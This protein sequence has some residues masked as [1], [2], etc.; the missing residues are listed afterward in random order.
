MELFSRKRSKSSEG[1][2]PDHRVVR[3]LRL[4]GVPGPSGLLGLSFLVSFLLRA[5]HYEHTLTFVDE[6]FF[7]SVAA[8]LMHGSVLYRDV[9]CNNQPLVIY[10]CNSLFQILGAHAIALHLGSLLL[11][12]LESWLLYQVGSHFFTARA[13]G[14]AALAYAVISTNFYTP[15]IIGF[16]SE[17]L[18]VVFTT[19]AVYLLLHALAGDRL[20]LLFWTGAFSFA[21]AASKPA[22][23]PEFLALAS[24]LACLAGLSWKRKMRALA[25]MGFGCAAGITVMIAALA[26]AATLHSWWNQS[27]VSRVHYVNQIGGATFLIHFARQPLIFGF[28]Y[29]W[30]WILIWGGRRSADINP[31][32]YRAAWVWLGAAFLG[33]IM[34]RRFYANYY[35]QVFPALSLLTAAGLDYLLRNGALK[36][37]RI[38]L[39]AAAMTLLLPFL[40]FQARTFAHWYFLFD[41]AAHRRVQMWEMCVIDR[42]QA[43]ISEQIRSVTR[44]EDRIF[45][46]GPDPEFYF[47]SGR[48][49]ATAYPFFDVMD[50]AQPPYGNGEKETLAALIKAPPPL[51][52]DS[53]REAQMADREGWRSLLAHHYRLWRED[54]GVR[55]YLR[56]D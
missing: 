38:A 17:Q 9:W 56:K 52:V 41:D 29:L 39:S 12:C 26:S 50:P 20:R 18:M 42:N 44:P 15:R 27:V 13:G 10:F 16:T 23:V 45:V 8:E 48:R 21:A 19:A 7:A 2:S 14:L 34:G 51:I 32:A 47:L 1:S 46:W 25:W 4:P 37:S 33:V 24:F 35:I 55:L 31:T 30:A 5:P 53:F 49:M 28:I 40:W 36:R 43:E 3:V 22:A 11:A 54:H 6:G